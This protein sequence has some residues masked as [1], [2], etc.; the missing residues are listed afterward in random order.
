MI[1][2]LLIFVLVFGSSLP[3]TLSAGCERGDRINAAAGGSTGAPGPIGPT[4]ATGDTGATGAT[5]AP[6]VAGAPG[7][8]GAT[9]APGVAGAPGD[10]GPPGPPGTPGVGVLDFTDFFAL[11]PGD[12]AA[13]VAPGTAV[14]FPQT[15][16]TSGVIVPLTA[17]T[18]LLPAV[19][20]YIVQFQVSVDEAGQ[21]MLR[22]NAAPVAD[23]VAGRAT[24][25]SQI[26]G[27]SLLTTTV[28]NSILEVINPA[29][30]A[31][32]LTI[33]P[34]AGGTEPVSAH[35]FIVRIQ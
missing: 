9:G 11:M 16:S 34:L 29:G 28:P 13:T 35:L 21:L 31:T 14:S 19:G 23:S 8:T 24:G 20:T 18:F 7:D 15:G 25:T 6:G 12:N 27:I 26:V 17:S 10:T 1:Y 33:T 22:L 2:R 32:A 3:A 4:G 5:G 30:N